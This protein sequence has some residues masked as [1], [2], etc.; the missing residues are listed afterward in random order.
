MYL[1]SLV[2]PQVSTTST[3]VF[4][5]H[6]SHGNHGSRTVEREVGLIP[7][8]LLF[9]FGVPTTPLAAGTEIFVVLIPLLMDVWRVPL[10]GSLVSGVRHRHDWLRDGKESARGAGLERHGREPHLRKARA[11]TRL[12]IAE[13]DSGLLFLFLSFLFPSFLFLSFLFLYFLSASDGGS[14]IDLMILP[15]IRHGLCR[16]PLR[17]P[18]IPSS[19][20]VLLYSRSIEARPHMSKAPL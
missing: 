8:P 1:V 14:Q 12:W 19:S 16:W 13:K 2:A 4:L 3:K 15:V 7:R 11:R 20:I 10:P 17:C 9:L 18:H 6:G 5:C